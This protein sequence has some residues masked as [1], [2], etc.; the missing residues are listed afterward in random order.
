MLENISR[1]TFG[2]ICLTF[3]TMMLIGCNEKATLF[4]QEERTIPPTTET[5]AIK[6]E[7][8]TIAGQMLTRTPQEV[9]VQ[10]VELNTGVCAYTEQ[11]A[12][13]SPNLKGV[14]LQ[15]SG[16]WTILNEEGGSDLRIDGYFLSASPSKQ[17]LVYGNSLPDSLTIVNLFIFDLSTRQSNPIV[18]DPNLSSNVH[19]IDSKNL[20]I[21]AIKGTSEYVGTDWFFATVSQ[22]PEG[23]FVLTNQG[24][25]TIN[26]EG[27]AKASEFG[28]ALLG[29]MVGYPQP[30]LFDPLGEY[31]TY[32][33][34]HCKHPRLI[35]RDLKTNQERWSFDQ[36]NS[37]GVRMAFPYWLPDGS[38]MVIVGGASANELFFFS[39]E[40]ELL[41]HFQF[42]EN[43]DFLFP[44]IQ[45]SFDYRYLMMMGTEWKEGY[46]LRVLFDR[47]TK[48]AYD[49]CMRDSDISSAWSPVA[50]LFAITDLEASEIIL[51]D[52]EKMM[53]YHYSNFD[54]ENFWHIAGW[55]ELP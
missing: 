49:L 12:P 54:H 44:N 10:K 30:I 42:P 38:E 17:H 27:Y 26:T 50:N 31:M 55:V 14:I 16:Y 43:L 2:L 45:F 40:G 18:L 52:V 9:V 33:C 51:F 28:P 5:A 29:G 19:W 25:L 48:L 13:A 37:D 47:K 8:P 34:Y 39:R 3:I 1:I 23:K 53:R 32:P 36:I 41:E 6:T 15:Y 20:F 4:R 21:Q 24:K 46:S 7:S 22:E 35:T 11:L